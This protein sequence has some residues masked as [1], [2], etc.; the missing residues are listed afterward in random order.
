MTNI[1]T[2]SAAGEIALN[3]AAIID[4]VKQS[5]ID[6]V[7]S[8]PDIVSCENVLWPMT[9]DPEL[10]V[11]PVC[12]EDEGVSI[13]AGLSYCERRA[14]LLI[15]HT[16]FL[17]S[18]NAIRAIAVE[19]G[20]PICMMVGLQGMEPDRELKDSK[21]YGI[22]IMEPILDAMGIDYGI[23]KEGADVETIIPAIDRAYGESRPFVF[24]VARS[25]V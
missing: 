13:C 12:K 20:L 16:G 15:Q 4:R 23:L 6:F 24:L 7:V 14:L 22:R 1:S 17:D 21:S 3:G 5:G 9:K 8:V 2:K 11:V 10:T 18:I 25:P 19:Y